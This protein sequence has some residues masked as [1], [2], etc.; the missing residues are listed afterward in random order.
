MNAINTIGDLALR[1]QLADRVE[2]GAAG[3]PRRPIEPLR[4]YIA[5]LDKDAKKRF[6]LDA[7]TTLPYLY[8]LCS[9][10]RR[11]SVDKAEAIQLASKRRVR[12]TDLRPD[13]FRGRRARLVRDV[14]A[15][16]G[17]ER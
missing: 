17:T 14:I 9:G 15:T 16:I 2:V 13:I 8:H 11:A 4:A 7:R 10:F 5:S 1:V 12:V 6:A 3:K